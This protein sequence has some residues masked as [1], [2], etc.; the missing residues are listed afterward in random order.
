[1]RTAVARRCC[2]LWM[3]CHVVVCSQRIAERNESLLVHFP[4]C[5]AHNRNQVVCSGTE[6][7]IADV[8]PFAERATQIIRVSVGV[9]TMLA[10]RVD[11]GFELHDSV[12]PAGLARRV[13]QTGELYDGGLD[14]HN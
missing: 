14:L 1:M 9:A 11:V 3:I 10:L 4:R 8:A 7:P 2:T 6:L 13:L 12:G 5:V